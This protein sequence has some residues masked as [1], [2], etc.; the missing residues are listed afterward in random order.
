MARFGLEGVIPSEKR[1][2]L[3]PEE[4]SFGENCEVPV[5]R[6]LLEKVGRKGA[7]RGLINI[8]IED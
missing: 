2:R 4:G 5:K 6:D 8:F 1:D 3:N 7:D